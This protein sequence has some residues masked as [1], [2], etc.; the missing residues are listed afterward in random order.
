VNK[1][2]LQIIVKETAN[3]IM[4]DLDNIEKILYRK[5]VYVYDQGV[6][7]GEREGEDTGYEKGWREGVRKGR[8]EG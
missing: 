6:N 4:G 1:A 5:L 2:K 3:E 7:D 8:D